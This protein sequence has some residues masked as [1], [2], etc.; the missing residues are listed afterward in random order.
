M[1]SVSE[2]RMQPIFNGLYFI[3]EDGELYSTRRQKFLRPDRDRYGYV[4][5]VISIDGNRMTLKA[6]RLVAEA[7]ISNPDNK[8]TVNHKNGIRDDN[9]VENLEWATV[10][11]QANDPLT[12]KHMQKVAAI[13]DYHAMGA[14]RNFGRK[15][16]AVFDGER[17]LGVYG[18][19][20]KAAEKY[21]ANIAKASECA[22]GTRKRAGGYRFCYV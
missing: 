7:F 16:T 18:S 2:R 12:R 9:R 6:H 3:T 5:Y 14:L 19:L 4:Y 10:K 17:L 13:T 20:K 22:N 8:P 15:Q 11:E 21:G 1:T